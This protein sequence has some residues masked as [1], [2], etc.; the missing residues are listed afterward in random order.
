MN[1]TLVGEANFPVEALVGPTHNVQLHF[2]GTVAA[3]VSVRGRLIETDN[4]TEYNRL[5]K[6]LIDAEERAKPK[7]E[8]KV[9]EQ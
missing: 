8:V 4:E 6:D 7:K 3:D 9:A 5:L 1:S 2:K